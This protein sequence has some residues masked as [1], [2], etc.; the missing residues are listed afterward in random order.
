MITPTLG[1]PSAIVQK[2][3]KNKKG[4]KK[5]EQGRNEPK[6]DQQGLNS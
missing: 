5:D 4:G 2:R 1:V 6:F 3:V